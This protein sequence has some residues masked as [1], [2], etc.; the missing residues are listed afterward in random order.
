MREPTD[1][2]IEKLARDATPVKAL[3]SPFVRAGVF[4]AVNAVLIQIALVRADV[5]AVIV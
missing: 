2:L 5:F 4:V 3:P 1:A